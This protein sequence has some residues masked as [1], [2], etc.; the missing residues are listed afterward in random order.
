M[1]EVT[2]LEKQLSDAKVFVENREVAQRL[3]RNADFKKLILDGFCLK[4]CARYAQESQDP[5]LT[6]AQQADALNMAQAAGHLRRYL[7]IQIQLG[8]HAEG[9]IQS[10]EEALVEVRS[11]GLDA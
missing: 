10:I 7:S 6:A 8:N 3:Y 5:A 9:Q 11:E 2:G 1:S 4:D